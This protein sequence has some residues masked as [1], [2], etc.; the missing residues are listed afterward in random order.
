MWGH[1]AQETLEAYLQQEVALSKWPE[2][3]SVYQS[4][5]LRCS[6]DSFHAVISRGVKRS[7]TAG[8]RHNVL[9]ITLAE[10][11][12]LQFTCSDAKLRL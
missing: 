5:S 12:E 1:G 8:K 2:V 4:F 7:K 10:I 9:A 3:D 11:C 6:I